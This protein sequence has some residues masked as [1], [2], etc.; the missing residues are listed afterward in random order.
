MGLS[1]INSCCFAG[2]LAIFKAII[3]G[4]PT[5][6]VTWKR[7]NGNTDDPEKYIATFDP[8]SNE[9]QLQVPALLSFL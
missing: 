5:P 1:T 3:T 2:K 6:T 4:N 9:Y 8:N 7:N